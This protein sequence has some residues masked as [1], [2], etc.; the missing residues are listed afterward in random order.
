MEENTTIQEMPD[1]CV[2]LQQEPENESVTNQEPSTAEDVAPAGTSDFDR[3]I[4]EAEERGYRRGLKEGM[5]EL[6]ELPRADEAPDDAEAEI[7]ILSHPRPS[8]WD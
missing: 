4:A 1:A 3:L 5:A 6:M 7:L 8:I 2:E